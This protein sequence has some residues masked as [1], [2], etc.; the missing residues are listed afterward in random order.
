MSPAALRQGLHLKAP[1]L[2]L[3]RTATFRALFWD[4][5]PNLL[6]RSSTG[7]QAALTSIKPRPRTQAPS[8]VKPHPSE[9]SRLPH[10]S[11]TQLSI[12]APFYQAPPTMLPARPH[13]HSLPPQFI[14]SLFS[15]L[16]PRH[17]KL[18]PRVSA[19]KGWLACR[20]HPA[21]HRPA[22]GHARELALNRGSS[23][24][25]AACL[26]WYAPDS[27]EFCI[28]PPQAPPP[29]SAMNSVRK[30]P[31]W[32]RPFF[33]LGEDLGNNRIEPTY[34]LLAGPL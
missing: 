20:A 11:L 13:P 18:L 4:T 32:P 3:K 31:A 7:T 25:F 26:L 30:V 24:I 5:I 29:A 15:W 10:D 22:P 17:E 16:F 9:K 27:T 8:A 34:Q 28:T 21:A 6:S 23:T 14:T 12:P 19:C 1:L 33:R 2:G